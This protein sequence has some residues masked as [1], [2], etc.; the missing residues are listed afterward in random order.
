MRHEPAAVGRDRPVGLA[1]A[2]PRRV[3]ATT[4]L[5]ITADRPSNCG[6]GASA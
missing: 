3:A 4:Q 1:H 6:S 5:P 2:H